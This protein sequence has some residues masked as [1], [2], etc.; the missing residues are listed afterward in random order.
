MN[1]SA[2]VKAISRVT[3]KAEIRNQY[4][5]S[6][7]IEASAVRLSKQSRADYL[8]EKRF[9]ETVHKN[10]NMTKYVWHI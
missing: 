8:G 3:L 9:L 4:L 7:E 1:F 5:Y 10:T 2:I 6:S